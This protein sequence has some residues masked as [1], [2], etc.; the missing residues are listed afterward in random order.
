M[1]NVVGNVLVDEN[2]PNIVSGREILKGLLHLLELGVRLDNQEVG[3]IC[4]SV[5]DSSQQEPSD[6]VLQEK[7]KKL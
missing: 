2:N 3:S 4:C 6:S 1:S 7:R 5:T